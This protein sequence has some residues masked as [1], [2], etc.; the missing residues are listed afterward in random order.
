MPDP[1]NSTPVP[2]TP[3]YLS[4]KAVWLGLLVVG[5]LALPLLLL[6]PNFKRGSKITI[7]V[8]TVVLTYASFVYTPMLLD[9]LGKRLGELQSLTK[10]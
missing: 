7:T 1:L 2:K 10:S 8:V 3:W 6:S 9:N 4:R 5:P